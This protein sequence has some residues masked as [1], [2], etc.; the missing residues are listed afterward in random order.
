MYLSFKDKE[1]RDNQNRINQTVTKLVTVKSKCCNAKIIYYDKQNF[2]YT[3]DR[4]CSKCK[5]IVSI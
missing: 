1:R 3:Q 5:E 4:I 2:A